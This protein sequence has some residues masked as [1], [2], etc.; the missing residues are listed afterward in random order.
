MIEKIS[1]IAA[2]YIEPRYLKP[3]EFVKAL[4]KITELKFVAWMRLS[5]IIIS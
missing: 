5:Y 4:E 2:G 1:F 3:I